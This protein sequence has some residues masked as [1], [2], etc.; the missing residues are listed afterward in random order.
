MTERHGR[1]TVAEGHR[2]RAGA[3]LIWVVLAVVLALVLVVSA[4]RNGPLT[5][6]ARAAA[7][8]AV[9]KCPSCDGISVADSSASTAAAVRQVVS[10]RVR[11][12]QSDQQ[13]ENYLVSRYGPSILLRP[14]TTGITALVWIL[15]LV[16]AVGG[17]GGL[18]LFFWRRR[19]P[20]EIP[21]TAEDRRLVDRALLHRH[22]V[23]GPPV[24]GD[25]VDG[26]LVP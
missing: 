12:G 5:P 2:R 9:L 19:R 26:D 16:A 20:V 21:V 18:G 6:A 17:A 10:A 25:R 13:I 23:D 3:G 8:D 24:A 15:P 14:P 22:T 7:L 4:S 11:A 1:R